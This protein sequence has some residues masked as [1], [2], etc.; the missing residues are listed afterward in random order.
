M[1]KDTEKSPPVAHLHLFLAFLRVGFFG[2]GGG[3]S[4]IP[5][6][7]V[8][9]VEKYKWMDSDEFGDLLAIGNTLPGPIAT[10][11]AGYI[12]YRVAGVLGAINAVASLTVPVIA[13]MIVLLTSMAA[14]KDQPWVQG[15]TA[16]VIPVVGVMLAVLTWQFIE[17]SQAGLGWRNSILLIALSFGVLEIIGIHPALLIAALLLFALLKPQ[18]R[19]DTP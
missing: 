10:K 12:G 19:G 5:L 9:A 8:E 3:P 6:V 1:V 4:S 16:A 11:M 14:V 17:K 15:I 13:I 18:K 7:H 2:F